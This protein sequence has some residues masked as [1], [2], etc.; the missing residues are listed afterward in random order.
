[1]EIRVHFI[2][3]FKIVEM[4][5]KMRDRIL[6]KNKLKP[7]LNGLFLIQ[8]FS[9]NLENKRCEIDSNEVMSN[10]MTPEAIE[11]LKFVCKVLTRVEVSILHDP[12][13]ERLVEGTKTRK[14]VVS[15]FY[16]YPESYFFE[17]TNKE[18][19]FKTFDIENPRYEI[20][21]NIGVFDKIMK[22][23]F[24]LS[25]QSPTIYSLLTNDNMRSFQLAFWNAGLVLNV[26]I[27]AT[28]SL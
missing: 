13:Y 22:L 4:A 28:Y 5:L 1:M 26:I 9:R 11:C 18:T 14:N 2:K 25:M 20:V 19:F 6:L 21:K 17:K 16:R 8:Q 3:C 10:K 23:N 24:E 12:Y 7:L 27:L 15:Y